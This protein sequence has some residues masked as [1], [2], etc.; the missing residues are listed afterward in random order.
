MIPKNWSINLINRYLENMIVKSKNS[1]T[2]LMIKKTLYKNLNNNLRLNMNNMQ[3]EKIRVD[4]QS[5]CSIC[6]EM[7]NTVSMFIREPN[8]KLCH[9]NCV[10]R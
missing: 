5:N 4:D 1:R 2:S 6:K 10:K 8:G 9:L 3:E 7:L